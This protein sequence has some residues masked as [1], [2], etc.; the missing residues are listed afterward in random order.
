VYY[1]DDNSNIVIKYNYTGADN[2]M[3]LI[4]YLSS[5]SSY[6]HPTTSITSLSIINNTL[7]DVD[8]NHYYAPATIYTH[9]YPTLSLL[10]SVMINDHHCFVN[11]IINCFVDLYHYH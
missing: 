5:T 9:L 11:I 1:V 2:L 8:M 6:L 7:R 4:H 10:M 3:F